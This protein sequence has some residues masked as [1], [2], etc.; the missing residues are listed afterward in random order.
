[1][2]PLSTPRLFAKSCLAATMGLALTLS[3]AAPAS[4][5]QPHADETGI[6]TSGDTAKDVLSPGMKKAEGNIAVFVQFKGKGAYEQTQSPAVLANKQAPINKQAEV[7]AIKTQVQSQAQAAARQS[8]SQALYTVHNTARG[9]VLQGNAAQI[10]ELARRG[11]VERITP[12]IAKERQNASSVV[13][14]KTVNTWTRE[15]TGYTGKDV[16]IAV[17]DSGVDYTHADFGGPGTAEAYQK[18]K[19]MPELPSADSGLIDRNKIAAGVDLVG[20]SYNASSTN[21]EQNTPHPDNNPLDCRPDGFG[22]GGHGTHVAGTAAGYGVNQDGTTFRGDYSKLTAEQLNQMKIGPGTAPEAKILPVRVFGCHGTTHMVIKALDTVLDPNGDG[23]FSDK[24]N[25]VNLSLGGEFAPVDDPESYIVNTMARQGVFTVAAAGNAN[26]YNGVGDTY[27]NS[28]SPANAAAGLSVANAYG[29]TQPTDQMKVLA[30]E[31]Q[32]GFVNGVYTSSFGYAAA[33]ADKLTGEVVKAPASNRY[34]CEAFS[35]QDAAQLKGKWV[36]IDWEDPATGKFPCGSAVRFNHVEAAGGQGVVLGSVQERHEVGIA[37]NATIPGFMLSQS[38]TDKLATAINDGTLRVELN[39]DY[40]AQGRTSHSKALDLVSSSA[41]GQHGSDGYIKPDVAAPGAEIVSAAVGGGT[42]GVA[43]TGTS[44]AAPHASGVAALVL[45]AHQDYSPTMLKA[46]LMNGANTDLKD[47]QG[48]TYA[49]DRVGSGMINA[50][51]AVEAKVLAY[52]TK[53]P[54]RVSTA[55]GVLEYTP[56]SGVQTVTRD[57]TLDNTDSRAHTYTPEYVASTSIP[58]VSFSL[59]STVSVGAG[60]KKNVTVTVTIDPAKLEKTRDPALE[61]RQS[62]RNV[63]GDKVETTAEGDRQYVASASGRVVFKED[64]AEA[65]RVPVHVAPK[66]VSAMRADTSKIEFGTG[67]EQ[68]VKLTGTTL[69]QG[70]YRSMLGVFELGAASG[71]IPTQNLTLAS[72]QVVDVQYVGAA[73]DAPA[74]AAAGKNPDKGN[75]YFGISTWSNWD[76]LHSGRSVEVS[77]DTN[78]DGQQDYVLEVAREKGLDFPLVKVW[79]ATGDKWDFINQYPLNSAWGD[80]DTNMMDSNV[81]VLGAPLKDLGLTSANAKDISYTVFTNTWSNEG[82]DYVDRTE[83]ATFNPFAPKVWF[84]GESAGVPGFFADRA[85]AELTA[86]RQA[87][88]FEA[89]ALFLHMHNGTGDL[90]GIG[91]GHGE[92]AQV[93]EV[94]AASANSRDARFKDVPADNQFYT[95]INWLAQRQITL[96][97][98]DGTF[99]PGENV[100]RGAMAAFFYRLNGSPQFTPPT[101]PTFSDVPTNHPFYKEIEW[102]A[103]RGITTGYGDGTF[104]PSDSVNRDAMAAFFYRNAGS[105]QF[106]APAR[107]PFADV[108][109]DSQF[110]KEI[111]WLAEQGIT[112]GWDDGTYR[113]GEPIHRDAMAAFLYRYHEKVLSRR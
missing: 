89:K 19:D 62:S 24:A 8:S 81:M 107:A 50:K 72:D 82:S 57:I 106:A 18:A 96:G 53:Q 29:T 7:Q 95:E 79:K 28:G 64:G 15:N 52:D 84:E 87:G 48:H 83:K 60:E 13:D 108:P 39:N 10:R 5:V 42:K 6:V 94:S 74:L 73:S 112:K 54:E 63:V 91:A 40:K 101:K 71:R 17:V 20:D 23:D 98:P 11:D 38:A 109:A 9:V 1:M 41:R 16:T 12:I 97:Y 78:G 61:K 34:G 68:K 59:P 76:V 102:M 51:A 32:A 44:M 49:V 110:Y 30:P 75:L 69:D 22:S 77:V 99:R 43:F 55:F 88:A 36:Y 45:Q 65:M 105:P 2:R 33:S 66:P 4:A 47:S 14:T 80:T 103:A 113:P 37:G 25:V 46:A 58:G 70:G 92:R 67:A 21:T 86:H 111:A 27:S 56:D 100:E 35:E 90:S 26:N 104:R 93:V 85:G 3:A 31:Q